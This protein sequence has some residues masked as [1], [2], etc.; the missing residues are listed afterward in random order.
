MEQRGRGPRAGRGPAPLKTNVVGKISSPTAAVNSRRGSALL[1]VLWATAALAAIAFAVGSTVRSE[2]ERAATDSDALRAYYLASAGIDRALLWIEWG[3]R[4]LQRPDRQP[5]LR[6]PHPRL[7]MEF[8]E[9]ET[10][11]ELIPES[12]KMNVNTAN[13]QDLARLIAA[14]GEPEHA[15]D[16]TQAIVDWRAPSPEGLTAFDQYYMSLPSS[17]RSRHSS[18]K[19]IEELLLV[20]GM[21]PELFYG[22]YRQDAEG[23]SVPVG[24]LRDCLSVYGGT[25][26]YDVNTVSPQL[27]YA[28]G[29]PPNVVAAIV[30]RRN[31]GPIAAMGDLGAIAGAPGMSKLTVIQPQGGGSIWTLRA[32]ARVRFAGGRLSE[33]PRSVAAMVKFLPVDQYNPPWHM[34]RWYDDNPRLNFAMP[35]PVDNGQVISLE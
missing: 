15:A 6:Q 9:G 8:P 28:L 35:P 10:V 33:V 14:A 1:T 13:P 4:G 29:L 19:E 7:V 20:R 17:F 21:T 11:V 32:T 18:L 26:S 12:S 5:W 22:G 27:M 31:L 3:Q 30:N 2:A 24:G 25:G 34:M 16:I 23:H